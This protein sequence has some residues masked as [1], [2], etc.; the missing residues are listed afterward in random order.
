MSDTMSNRNATGSW[1]GY[2][3][4]SKVGILLALQKIKKLLNK[5]KS[6]ES[7]IVEYESAEDIDIKHGIKV[8]TRH[9]VKTY[10]DGNYPN[11]YKDVLRETYP[12]I[13]GELTMEKK[14]FQYRSVNEDGSVGAIEVDE[15]SR[16]LHTVVEVKGFEL[17]KEEFAVEMP[18]NTK[19]IENPNKIKLYKYSD[20]VYYCDLAKS[21]GRDKLEEYCVKEVEL[22]LQKRDHILKEFREAH[23]TKLLNILDALDD[24][25][26]RERSKKP[27]GY[28]TLQLKEIYEILISTKSI[29][30][31]NSQIMRE[32][33]FTVLDD[34]IDEL[35]DKGTNFNQSEIK[36]VTSIIT[37]IYRLD[38]K[39]FEEL[40]IHLNPDKKGIGSFADFQ[41]LIDYIQ[42]DS[43]KD[44]LYS[45]LFHITKQKFDL[46]YLGYQEDKYTLSLINRESAQVKTVIKK[47]A[48]NNVYLNKIYERNYLINGHIDYQKITREIYKVKDKR[49]SNWKNKNY[50][51]KIHIMNSEMEFITAK[52]AIKK[53][54]EG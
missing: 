7:W 44:I 29:E 36:N 47:L 1:H 4:Q 26:R 24:E 10:R 19:Y 13:D 15:N 37:E 2:T 38:D 51:N 40:I 14:A 11:D 30:R 32:G 43:L 48:E 21:S 27:I 17:S 18:R 39:R 52:N 35:Q 20:N 42:S 6:L 33:L 25:V 34:Y 45:C 9:Q 28:P 3:H 49:D 5:E 31:T 23:K 54:N 46:D 50:E 53:I 12:M 8:D 22:I 16:Y 41:V